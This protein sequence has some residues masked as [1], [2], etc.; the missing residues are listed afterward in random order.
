MATRSLIGILDADGN[1]FR[2]RYCHLN[3]DPAQQLPALGQAL[4]KHH[5]GDVAQLATS[6][7]KY[8][9]TFLAANDATAEIADP[10]VRDPHLP[11]HLQPVSGVGY[12]H[13]TIPDG[14][15]PITGAVDGDAAGMIAWLYFL[16]DHQ[17]RVYRGGDSRWKPF[18][19]FTAVDLNH[20]HLAD[21]TTRQVVADA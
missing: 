2:A 7:M 18:G 14:T 8:D 17:V 5:D 21:L 16:V 19:R 20:L 4:H 6:L 1:T 11:D 9:W 12:R 3:G 10:S 15:P 13:T